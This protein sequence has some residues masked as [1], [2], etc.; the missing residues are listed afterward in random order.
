MPYSRYME[1]VS[2]TVK[3]FCGERDFPMP[4][5]IIE[6]GRSIVG[7]AGVTLY[8]VGGV[9]EIPGVR[10]YVSVDG[11]MA[12]APRHALYQA[13]YTFLAAAR[14][15]Q[16]PAQVVTVA[17]K[18]C[19][20]GD[21]LGENVPLQPVAPGDLVAMLSTGAYHYSMASNYNRIPRPAMVLVGEK[22]HRL[23]IRRETLE[24]LVRNDLD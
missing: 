21:L 3:E 16:P 15:G 9:K 7:T 13:D 14:A 2:R 19:E 18:C 8:R 1:E 6:P 17:G 24:D 20:S 23:I 5:V 4:F 22:G 10:T 11:S 12:D